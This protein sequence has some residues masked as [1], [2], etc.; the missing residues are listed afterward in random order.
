MLIDFGISQAAEG[1]VFEQS[2]IHG[3]GESGDYTHW[4]IRNRWAN[5][6]R[7]FC[8]QYTDYYSYRKTMINVEKVLE[9]LKIRNFDAF[10]IQ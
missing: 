6:K 10:E 2:T 8:L 1:S 4:E 7:K 9:S 5:Q 3:N